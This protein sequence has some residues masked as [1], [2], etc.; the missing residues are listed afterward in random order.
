MT[1]CVWA[2][3]AKLKDP[4]LQHLAESLPATVLHSRAN[5]TVTKYSYTFQ[6]WKVW[7]E[8]RS[9]VSVFPVSEVHFA[10]YLQHL[11][12]TV[13]S[14][15]VVQEAVNAIGWVHQ[16]LG[17]EPIMQL[18]FVRATMAG[19]KRQL[20]KPKVK[21]EPISM[22]MLAALVGSLGHSPSLSEVRLVAASCL[23]M[24]ATFLPMMRLPDCGALTSDSQMRAWRCTTSSKIN[25]YRQGN[26][27]LRAHTGSPTCPVP[28]ME[29][30]FSLAGL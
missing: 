8:P 6:R 28:M 17:L 24:F 23:S 2:E 21:K 16:L 30:Y 27:V 18:P 10:L 5:S 14:W 15:S 20:A 29:R 12:E 22:D 7:E 11:G 26:S 9:E 19:L 25:Q 4:E 1:S 13:H 3:L